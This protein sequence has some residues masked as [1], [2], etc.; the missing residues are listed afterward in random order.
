MEKKKKKWQETGP[1]KVFA[2]GFE[3]RR[4]K[5]SSWEESQREDSESRSCGRKTFSLLCIVLLHLDFQVIRTPSQNFNKQSLRALDTK[6]LKLRE[7]HKRKSGQRLPTEISFLF[8]HTTF[9]PDFT[10]GRLQIKINSQE[11]K[12]VSIGAK[13]RKR[14]CFSFHIKLSLSS[15][16]Q[17]LWRQLLGLLQKLLNLESA[18]QNQGGNDKN[19]QFGSNINV[20]EK[21]MKNVYWSQSL[22]RELKQRWTEMKNEHDNRRGI[23]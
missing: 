9:S 11:N 23:V 21:K 7:N 14:K 10:W 4:R 8:F 15:L 13:T 18:H 19:F 20:Q 16:Y 17:T 1:L 22:D 12:L 2:W 3:R 6:K 5:A